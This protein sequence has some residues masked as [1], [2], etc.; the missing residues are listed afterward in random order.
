MMRK[1]IAVVF[2]DVHLK[3]GNEDAVWIAFKF[4]IDYMVKHGLKVLIFAGDMFDDRSAQRSKQLE[5]FDKML[6]LCLAHKIIMYAIPGNHDKTIYEDEYNF[7]H[8]F[9]HHPAIKYFSK[10]TVQ[11][12]HGRTFTFVPFY[13]DSVLVP[14]LEDQV[15]GDVLISHFEMKGSEHLGHVSEKKSITKKTLSKWEKTYLGHFHN[16][17]NISEHITHLP[18][19]R[20]TNFGEDVN[21][22]FALIHDDLSYELIRGK[23]IEYVKIDIHI[24]SSTEGELADLRAEYG[25]SDK[26]VRFEFVGTD[27]ALKAI[28]KK[29]FENL[30]IQVKIK[31][32]KVFDLDTP[33][34]AP[35]MI[36]KYGEEEI[37][38]SFENFCKEK[39]YDLNEGTELLVKFF[40]EKG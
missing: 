40:K 34:E 12:I 38:E 25:N 33:S 11:L 35:E 32:T 16:E 4:M 14:M 20:Q 39:G 7:M 26:V 8:P 9:R 21:K 2:N 18:S 3:I 23:F 1:P 28:D 13:D 37:T 17:Q 10:P 29:A 31:Y 5:T 15:G 22:G 19:F 27:T 30:G 24:D 36:E 6:D